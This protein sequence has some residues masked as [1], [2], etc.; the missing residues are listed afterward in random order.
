MFRPNAIFKMDNVYLKEVMNQAS[1]F[2]DV[3]F[4]DLNQRL[5]SCIL[6]NVTELMTH[7]KFSGDIRKVIRNLRVE[8]PRIMGYEECGLLV[9]DKLESDSFYT[10]NPNVEHSK[11]MGLKKIDIYFYNPS[12]CLTMQCYNK[13]KPMFVENPRQNIRFVEGFD[14]LTPVSDYV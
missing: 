2:F 13:A 9:I 5:S 10:V 11:L 6:N 4:T 3:C 8:I 7:F 14:N 12:D 1:Y